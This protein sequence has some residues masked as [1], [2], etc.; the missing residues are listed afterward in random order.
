M[1]I[2]KKS[3]ERLYPEK[4]FN[5]ESKVRYSAKFNSYN[6]NIK[7]FRNRM[8]VNL[9]RKWKGVDDDIKIGLIQELLNKVFKTNKKTTNTE[10][11]NIFIKKISFYAPKTKTDPLLE[12][13][14][15]RVNEGY[16]YGMID[17]PNLVWCNS[18]NKLGSYEFGTDTIAISKILLNGEVKFLDYVM[19]H[20]ILHKKLKFENKNRKNLYHTKR[21][22]ER[23]REFKNSKEIEKGLQGLTG[24]SC[25]EN[26]SFIKKIKFLSTVKR[27]L[28]TL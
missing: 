18:K 21:F 7:L 17:K 5:Y 4:E 26:K 23:E 27:V 8:Q 22:R 19:Y 9:S 1:S 20:E 6:A 3:F 16:F 12:N 25:L 13:C 10:L 14:F 15:E 2:I 28:R 11:Y 24:T